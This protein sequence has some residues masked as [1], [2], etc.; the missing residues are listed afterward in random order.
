MSKCTS[1]RVGA[2][3]LLTAGT[4][5][6]LPTK[7]QAQESSDVLLRCTAQAL[8]IMPSGLERRESGQFVIEIS[9]IPQFG[10]IFALRSSGFSTITTARL[11][12]RPAPPLV[13]RA[14]DLSTDSKW[15][16]ENEFDLGEIK[17]VTSIVIDR[18]DGSVYYTDLAKF[19]NG[20]TLLTRANGTCEKASKGNLF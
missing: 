9:Q 20:D 5:L 10:A 17:K 16:V 12:T 15:E 6:F 7:A 19:P 14:I 18:R 3:V 4:W 1:K 2:V 11:F 8:A 13:L